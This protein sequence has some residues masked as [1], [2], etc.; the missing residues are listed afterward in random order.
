QL[1]KSCRIFPLRAT[2]D[3]IEF[4]PRSVF[5]LDTNYC[6]T[7]KVVETTSWIISARQL[8]TQLQKSCRIFPLRATHDCIEFAPRSVLSLLRYHCR[9][10]KPRYPE[11]HSVRKFNK[12]KPF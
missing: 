11:F 9:N 3:C 5:R 10:F 2:H 12:K 7:L 6:S 1:Q 8:F 4:A